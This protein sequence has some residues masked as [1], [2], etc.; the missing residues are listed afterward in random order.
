MTKPFLIFTLA[1][2]MAS[3]GE[4]AGHER[5]KTR[6]RPG[7]AALLGMI[8]AALGIRRE[9]SEGQIAL[10]DG[11]DIAVRVEQPGHPLQDFHTVQTVPNS[12]IKNPQT[13]AIALQALQPKDNAMLTRRDYRTDVIFGAAIM[14]QASARWS[15]EQ[16]KSAL[17]Q[18]FFTLYLGRKSCPLSHP[19]NPEL[20]SAPNIKAALKDAWPDEK[21]AGIQNYYKPYGTKQSDKFKPYIAISKTA[22]DALGQNSTTTRM[23]RVNDQPL[24]RITWHF[25]ERYEVIHPLDNQK[26]PSQ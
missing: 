19:L 12:R 14:A 4:L 21:F 24:N 17:E 11:Y 25:T 3:F 8:G 10:A 26:D 7:K 20:I 23:E 13:R 2:P 1:A 18:P 5:R 9:D 16:I 22:H 6:E 15:L